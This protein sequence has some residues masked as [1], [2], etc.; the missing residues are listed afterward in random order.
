MDFAKH[1]RYVPGEFSDAGAMSEV[2]EDLVD[3]DATHGT[4]GNRFFYC[5]TPPTAYPDIVKRIGE[6]GLQVGAKIVFEKPFGR[7]LASA[8][9]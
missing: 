6:A 4:Q 5:A 1:L 8:R 9:S 2:A 7:D 3:I